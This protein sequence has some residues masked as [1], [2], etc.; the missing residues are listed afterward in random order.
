M[1]DTI[2]FPFRPWVRRAGASI[3]WVALGVTIFVAAHRLLS[4]SPGWSSEPSVWLYVAALWI[5]GAKVWGGTLRPIVEL[6]P[7]GLVVRPIHTIGGRRIRWESLLGTEKMVPGDRM[8]IYY[9]TPRG[10]RFL[11]LNLNLVRGRRDLERTID[12]RL[13][14]A[15]FVEKSVGR[16]RYRSRPAVTSGASGDKG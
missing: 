6:G 15:G 7:D 12:D 5:G 16:S 13:R 10:M 11:A 9:D 2:V 14:D 8:I 4:R 3:L 1:S